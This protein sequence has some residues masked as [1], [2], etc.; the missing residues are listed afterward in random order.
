MKYQV[1]I[2]KNDNLLIF[3][4]LSLKTNDL[5][6]VLNLILNSTQIVPLG[7]EKYANHK[8]CLS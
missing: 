3:V 5:T 2:I 8:E 1:V 7:R 4:F 6:T